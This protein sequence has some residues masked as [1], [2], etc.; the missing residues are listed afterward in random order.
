MNLSS[1]IIILFFLN[2]QCLRET[3]KIVNTSNPYFS[4]EDNSNIIFVF[5]HMKHGANSPC[6]GLNDYYADIFEQQWKGFCELTKKGF[7]QLFKLGKIFQQRYDKLLNIKSKNPDVNKIISYASKENKTLMSSNAF[8]YGMYYNNDTPVEEQIVVPTRN[9]KIIPDKELIPIFYFGDINNCMGWKNL[10]DKI[11]E[12]KIEPLN[13]FFSKFIKSYENIFNLLNS[14]DKM[15]YSKSWFEK[16]NLFCSSYISNYYD[17]RYKNIDI[18]QQLKYTE[19]QF[20]DLYYDCNLFNLYKY[21]LIQYNGEAKDV[22][23]VILSDLLNDMFRYMD[24]AIN[25]INN[26]NPKFLSYMG[27]DSTIAAMQ[28]ILQR[29]FNVKTKI[30]NFGSNQIFLLIKNGNTYEIKYFYND[31]LLLNINYD[32][33]KNRILDLMKKNEKDLVYFCQGFQK[34]DYTIIILFSTIV[35]LFIA[36]VSVCLYHRTTLCERKKYI[37]IEPTGKSIEIRNEV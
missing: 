17:E 34:K 27:H 20:Y 10:V 2:I 1:F 7:L 29:L 32:E 18:F 11:D 37:S 14:R 6:Y 31:E 33:F 9:F 13:D 5:N 30:M 3:L 19:E 12:N 8:F 35:A 15:R 28:V 16:I 23:Q 24:F 21:T 36:N 26:E 4:S 25:N 22:P